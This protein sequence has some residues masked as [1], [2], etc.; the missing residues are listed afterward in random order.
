MYLI[1][2][3]YNDI[4]IAGSDSDRFYEIAIILD[5]YWKMRGVWKYLL[6]AFFPYTKEE[7]IIDN[8]QLGTMILSDESCLILLYYT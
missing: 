6:S 1:V 2:I 5:M 8:I 4:V 7:D 3:Q